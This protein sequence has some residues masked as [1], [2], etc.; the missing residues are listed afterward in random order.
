MTPNYSSYVP[1]TAVILV[2]C[3]QRT[4]WLPIVDSATAKA[5]FADNAEREPVSV[6]QE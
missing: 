6:Y 1:E 2:T 4:G 5:F 3:L